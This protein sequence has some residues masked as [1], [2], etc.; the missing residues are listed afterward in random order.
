MSSRVLRG[1][2]DPSF[3]AA[4]KGDEAELSHAM[5]RV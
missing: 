1:R 4:A 5:H 3:C 2:G